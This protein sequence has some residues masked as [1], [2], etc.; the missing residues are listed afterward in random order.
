MK[1]LN[2][3]SREKSLNLRVIRAEEA[4]K[5]A[6]QNNNHRPERSELR[7]QRSQPVLL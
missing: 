1:V 6:K 4:R 3:N 5:E 7:G 2:K